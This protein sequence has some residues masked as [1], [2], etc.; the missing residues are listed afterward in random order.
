MFFYRN[1]RQLLC[2]LRNKNLLNKVNQFVNIPIWVQ[3]AH[4]QTT[5]D[6]AVIS[7]T[8]LL[9]LPFSNASVF[10]AQRDRNFKNAG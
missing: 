10:P 9:V 3:S 5:V 6:A 7:D 2:A 8:T 4:K 1:A